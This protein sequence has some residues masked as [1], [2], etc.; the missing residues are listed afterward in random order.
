MPFS[1]ADNAP[2]PKNDFQG[3]VTAWPIPKN[4]FLGR[5]MPWPT[6][7]NQCPE[8]QKGQKKIENRKIKKK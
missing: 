2:A 4:Q 1:G 8:N 5:V 7:T 3:W 6:P